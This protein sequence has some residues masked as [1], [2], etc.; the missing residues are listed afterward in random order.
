[1]SQ[2][3]EMQSDHTCETLNLTYQLISRP[4]P[5]LADFVNSNIPEMQSQHT[6]EGLDLTFP[7]VS[8][9]EAKRVAEV[10]RIYEAPTEK[11]A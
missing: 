3:D 1:M 10:V 9:P 4:Q 5:I 8:K 11:A 7:L 2:F 6:C